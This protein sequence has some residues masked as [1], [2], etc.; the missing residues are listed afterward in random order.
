MTVTECSARIARREIS[1]LELMQETIASIR[2]R[3]GFNSFI[4]KTF[5][6][7]LEAARKL[8]SER[9]RG[10]F[11]GIPIA[12]KDLFYTRGVATTGGSQIFKDFVPDFDGD[13]V[14]NLK[15]SGAISVGKTN[16]HELAYGIRCNNP[17]FGPVL[18]PRDPNRIPGGSSGGSATL[19]AA[20]LLCMA[21]GTDSGGS[22]RIPASYCGIVG[23]KPTYDLLSRR[24]I[25]PLNYSLDHAGPLASCVE[26]C[27]I[28]LN[29]MSAGG[30]NFYLERKSDLKGVRI[31]V[32]DTFF[33]QGV[34]RDIVQTIK[35][36]LSD[37]QRMGAIVQDV[38]LPDF[39]EV[40]AASRVIQMSEATALYVNYH[41]PAQ[42]GADVWTNIQDGRQIFAHEY[43]NA[44]RLRGI[45]RRQMDAVWRTVNI[46]V[47]PTT[48]I[49][50]PL[51]DATTVEIDGRPEDVRLASTRLVRGWNYLGEPALSLPCGKDSLGLPIG[52]QL[53]ARPYADAELLQIAGTVEQIAA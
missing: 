52:M 22:I 30:R 15:S 12:H 9:N 36:R 53:I 38:H 19:V 47:T 43:V 20:G 32:P 39:Q 1:C 27:A 26:D 14:A 7:A 42:F 29:A 37:M 48:A 5:D 8:D 2:H 41:D 46:I 31:G 11:H 28:A 3:D 34:H 45:F 10:T 13:V 51:R 18:N 24:G 4:T 23:I 25:L 16:L 40:N 35:N 50:A 33:F 6:E 49:T 17:H 44:Q 21:T